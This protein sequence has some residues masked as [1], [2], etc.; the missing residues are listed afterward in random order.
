M[1]V[2]ALNKVNKT[3]AKEFRRYRAEKLK[4]KK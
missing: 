4:P 3:A 1:A 2:K